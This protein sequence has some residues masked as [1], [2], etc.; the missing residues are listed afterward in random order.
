LGDIQ[1]AVDAHQA[2]L[3]DIR[4]HPTSHWRPAFRQPALTA[5]FG[6]RYV[7]CQALDNTNYKGGPIQLRDYPAGL[8]QMGALLQRSP[9]VLLLCVCAAVEGCHRQVVG[10]QLSQDLAVP[11]VHL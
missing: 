2:L 11:L 6:E 10:D 1:G 3:V 8:A 7:W 9:A 4:D 5:H